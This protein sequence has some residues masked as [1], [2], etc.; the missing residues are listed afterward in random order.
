MSWRSIAIT[1]VRLSP[2]EKTALQAI[3]DSSS[4]GAAI[5]LTVVREFVGAATA[6]R[7]AVNIDDTVPDSARLHII[8]RTRWMWLCEFPQLKSLQTEARAKLNESA[9]AF[10]QLVAAGKQNIE[11]PTAS[12]N[13]QGMWNSANKLNPRA[14]PQPRPGTTPPPTNAYANPDAPDDQA[15]DT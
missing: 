5:L 6:G 7:Y 14:F 10:L 8:N 13:T 15:N 1:D 12:G 11:P 2:A 4:I 3:Q 9:E